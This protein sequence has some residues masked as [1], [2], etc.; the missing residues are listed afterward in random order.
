MSFTSQF[1]LITFSKL[2]QIKTLNDLLSAIE[3]Q[4][5][6]YH[7]F[8][9]ICKSFANIFFFPT[10]DVNFEDSRCNISSVLDEHLTTSVSLPSKHFIP[11]ALLSML[12]GAFVQ[13]RSS[14]FSPT[15][16][17]VKIGYLT[18]FFF[19][20]KHKPSATFSF[21]IYSRGYITKGWSLC[22]AT[23]A[24]QIQGLFL[25]PFSFFYFIFFSYNCSQSGFNIDQ[26]FFSSSSRHTLC[27]VL[28]RKSI[29][30]A[31]LHVGFLFFFFIIKILY[32]IPSYP[33]AF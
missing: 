8:I 4:L 2:L 20:K 29:N 5:N 25:F 33:I 22:N 31:Y 1:K 32:P 11:W 18:G 10:L 7:K 28:I 24:R 19:S 26:R 17:A 16:I 6:C 30:T 23:K 12:K 27:R 3:L 15:S 13:G 21:S 14:I 9:D